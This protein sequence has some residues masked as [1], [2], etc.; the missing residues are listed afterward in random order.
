MNQML[1]RVS[2]LAAALA[3]TLCACAGAETL[4]E[5]VVTSS[6]A[7]P[8][9]AAFGAA[10]D[11]MN[12]S[13]GD[14]V[15]K[16]QTVAQLRTTRV[17]APCEGTVSGVF[18]AEGDLTDGVNERY[19]AVL[20]V[21]PLGKYTVSATTEKAYNISE[22]RFVHIGETVF[23]RCVSDGSH[24]GRGVVKGYGDVAIYR[25]ENY[26]AKSCIG[27]GDV[28]ATTPVAVKGSG[29]ILKM[30][31][32]NGD[33][34][35][36]G[37]LLFETVD[38]ALDGMYSPGS[39]VV[40]DVSGI[41]ATVDAQP[42]ASVEKGGKILTVYTDESLQVQLPVAEADLSLIQVGQKVRLEFT[43]DPN[44]TTVFE[45][46]VVSLSYLN[47]NTAADTSAGGTSSQTTDPVYTA[48][49]SF[50]P[51]STVRM[52]MTVLAYVQD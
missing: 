38:G 13:P 44:Q 48:I 32:K 15:E 33:S 39:Q 18:G 41:V 3:L 9:L 4:F 5:G 16:G 28:A 45:G 7:T 37:E 23:L 27:R 26:D 47:A 11:Q 43:W 50:T 6:G 30:H 14:R 34:V 21:E 2:A 52:G 24:Q 22:N 51:D 40:S 35:E 46:E 31:V 17:Y 12:V 36:R 49:V 8:V 25:D 20:Y 1:K 29:S 42:G 10:V 19:G